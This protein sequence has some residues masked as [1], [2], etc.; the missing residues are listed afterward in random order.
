MKGRA[1]GGTSDLQRGFAVNMTP[2]FSCIFTFPASRH[3]GKRQVS[4]GYGLFHLSWWKLQFIHLK[5]GDK[6]GSSFFRIMRLPSLGW[7]GPVPC[8]MLSSI[9]GLYPLD[10][11]STHPAADLATCVLEKMITLIENHWSK[12]WGRE[13]DSLRLPSS[14]GRRGCSALWTSEA[15]CS[16]SC[17]VL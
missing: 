6:S 5:S 13:A 9:P 11:R 17:W 14:L 7:D 3:L 8:R 16:G 15:S 4:V 10:F 12:K 1:C 2:G